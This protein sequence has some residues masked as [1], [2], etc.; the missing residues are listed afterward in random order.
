M[1]TTAINSRTALSLNISRTG[2]CCYLTFAGS[3]Y[4]LATLRWNRV[5]TTGCTHDTIRYTSVVQDST[6]PLVHGTTWGSINPTGQDTCALL[7]PVGP[8]TG[9]DLP[10]VFKLYDNYPNP[11]NPSTTI[12]YDIPKNSFVKL[13]IYDILGKDVVILVNEK[14]TA[15]RYD[16]VWNAS[17]Y[18][19]GTYFY[20]LETDS[21][22][23]VKKMVLVK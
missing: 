15:G 4:R 21:Y 18:A 23:D 22:T 9:N 20:K 1:T 14:K 13:V 12:K 17:N 5:D 6:T 10:T 19:S 11:F 7:T 2:A 8:T 16:I 3:P